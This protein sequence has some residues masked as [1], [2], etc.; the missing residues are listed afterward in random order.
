[1]ERKH[2]TG[3]HCNAGAV[4]DRSLSPR[5]GIDLAFGSLPSV[6][7]VTADFFTGVF[8]MNIQGTGNSTINGVKLS[9]P[10]MRRLTLPSPVALRRTTCS[11]MSAS[12]VAA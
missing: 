4:G 1:M 12:A 6:P 3:S 7:I 5:T 11:A 9:R 2:P 10:T 8:P